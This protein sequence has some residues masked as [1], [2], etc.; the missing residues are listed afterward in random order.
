MKYHFKKIE[1]GVFKASVEPQS[2]LLETILQGRRN[3]VRRK[4]QKDHL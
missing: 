4:R 1:P 3:E 2:P